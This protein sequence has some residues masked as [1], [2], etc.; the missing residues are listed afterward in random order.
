MPAGKS[1]QVLGLQMM[2]PSGAP[3]LL[4]AAPLLDAVPPPLEPLDPELPRDPE[5]LAAIPSPPLLEPALL[6]DP[7]NEENPAS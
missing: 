6:L 2:A 4:D 3:P 5:L 7:R 1:A